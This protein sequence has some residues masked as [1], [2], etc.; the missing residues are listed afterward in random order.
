MDSEKRQGDCGRHARVRVRRATW[1]HVRAPS[2]TDRL[3]VGLIGAGW[4]SR[5]HLAAW[6]ALA[7][8]AAVVA[9][10]D[11]SSENAATRASEFGIETTYSSASEM[12]AQGGH[13]PNAAWTDEGH[14]LGTEPNLSRSDGR[15]W[16]R[17][18][19][20][21]SERGRD[22]SLCQLCRSRIS[23]GGCRPA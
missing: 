9:I 21:G 19:T 12:L 4:V 11:P 6:R 13:A 2:M 15:G 5:H 7:G 3:R 1:A 23:S 16:R 14:G 10:A 18:P 20:A 22:F 8:E 17:D